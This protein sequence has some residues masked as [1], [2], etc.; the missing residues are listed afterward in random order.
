MVTIKEILKFN[1]R[2][3]RKGMSMAD[4]AEASGL[5]YRTY[6]SIED[7]SRWPRVENL[8]AIA[9]ALGVPPAR[10]FQD[11][12][13]KPTTAEAIAVIQAALSTPAIVLAPRI[14][15]LLS[16]IDAKSSLLDDLEVVLNVHVDS[17]A[18]HTPNQ[19]QARPSRKAR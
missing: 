17:T 18:P 7:G 14:A 1:L 11:P 2:S 6:Q 13:L 19:V 10:L 5:P 3:L 8:D 4:L 12:A 16:A 15:R 9:K